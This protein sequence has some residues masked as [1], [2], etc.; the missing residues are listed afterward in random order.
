MM[1]HKEITAHIRRRLAASGI[2]AK[3]KMAEACGLRSVEVVVPSYEARFT[4]EEIREIALI[5]KVNGLTGARGATIN[6]EH[7]ALLTEKIQW[8]FYL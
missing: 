7:E 3:C 1:N 4:A 2:K 6:P 8:S 5:A